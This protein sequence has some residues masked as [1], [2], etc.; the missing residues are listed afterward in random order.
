MNHKIPPAV[1]ILDLEMES[2]VDPGAEFEQIA[3]GMQFTEG[4]VW[5]PDRQLFVYSDIR[6][7][8][9]YCWTKSGGLDVFR[10]P[11]NKANGNTIDNQGRQLTCEEETRRLTRTEAD[12]AVTVLADCYQGRKLNST[13]DVV[14]KRDDTIWF[15]DPTY[16]LRGRPSEQPGNYVY[17]LDPGATE[18]A[19]VARDFAEPN[20]LC[21]SPDE[22]FLYIA[23]SH[24]S[25][26][27]IRRFRVT[28]NNELEDDGL[29]AVISPHIPDGMRIDSRGRLYTT[30]GDGVQV[31][32][33]DG[34]MIGK[35]LTPEVAANC[36]FGGLDGKSLFITASTSVWR[37]PLR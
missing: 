29:F 36:C 30:A 27:L 11:S 6:T 4:P 14:V 16:G 26:H 18:P 17:R 33:P 15:T 22:K 32:R 24:V 3:S 9:M 2:I 1:E 34:T 19:P 28:K 13:N 5:L 7:S 20:G 12:G 23:D 37:V 8:K 35:F 21:F 31:F 10:D 25:R